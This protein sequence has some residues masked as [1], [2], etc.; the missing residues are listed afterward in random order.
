MEEVE[1]SEP[2]PHGCAG[3]AQAPDC[4]RRRGSR[5]SESKDGGVTVA[6]SSVCVTE[7]PK[8]ELPRLLAGGGV[9]RCGAEP[10]D[11][12][13]GND[14]IHRGGERFRGARPLR[15]FLGPSVQ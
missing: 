12:E 7:K 5:K 3:S 13:R 4:Q 10:S 11:G 8:P 6:V 15:S 1:A 2:Q 14:A 9:G